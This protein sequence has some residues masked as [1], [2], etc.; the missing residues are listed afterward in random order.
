M[1]AGI[2]TNQ[3]ITRLTP[4]ADVLSH[5]DARVK[6]VTSQAIE[7]AS[8]DRFTLARDAVVREALPPKA[9]ALRDGFAVSADATRDASSYAPV[10]LPDAPAFV[11]AGDAMPAGTDS[12]L[13][14]DAVTQR[15][16]V[17]EIIASATPGDGV[18]PQGIDTD[19]GAPL[20]KM[21]TLLRAEAIAVLR[22]AGITQVTARIPKVAI[23]G[24]KDDRI[25]SAA[26]GWLSH[27][28]A[29]AGA[30]ALENQ[31]LASAL[32]N[33]TADTVIA[34]GGTGI[35]PND[36][37]V[38]TLARLGNVAFHGIAITPGETAA[39]GFIGTKPVL[40]IPGRLDTTLACWLMLGEPMIARLCGRAPDNAGR[41]MRL[42]RK[43][44]SPLGVT[45]MIPVA[46]DAGDAEPL[47]ST[48]LSLRTLAR[49]GGWISVPAQSEGYPAGVPVTVRAFP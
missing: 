5:M 6:P 32:Q 35:G 26:G 31:D 30:I 27:A 49:A 48:Y 17:T 4:L 45:E 38:T 14:P 33:E 1:A 47:A 42:S 25:I 16:S 28:I 7:I 39:L 2:K 41:T 15:G 3:R 18:L 23:A 43:V 22:A 9:S 36:D 24:D 11:V 44:A 21:G 46:C 34:I 40:L 13:P 19:S 8:A 29:S 12:I 10:I 37:A 20:F